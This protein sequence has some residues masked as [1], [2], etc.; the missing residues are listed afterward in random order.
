MFSTDTIRE[1]FKDKK[2]RKVF[3]KVL[4]FVFVMFG[5]EATLVYFNPLMAP[6]LIAATPIV[7]IF[8]IC[9]YLR[10]FR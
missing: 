10:I 3:L 1:I 4:F 7:I 5:I 6:Y 2:V 9:K 8:V